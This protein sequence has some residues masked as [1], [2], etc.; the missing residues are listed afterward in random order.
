M[1]KLVE[2]PLALQL[3][4]DSLSAIINTISIRFS[5]ISIYHRFVICIYILGL[6]V[7]NKIKSYII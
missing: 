7:S 6:P 1:E 2:I 5:A 3:I 4:G